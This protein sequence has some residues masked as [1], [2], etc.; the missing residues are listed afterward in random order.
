M[1]NLGLI[2]PYFFLIFKM[3]EA[4]VDFFNVLETNNF[5][6]LEKCWKSVDSLGSPFN[7][8]ITSSPFPKQ[9]FPPW[10]I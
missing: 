9:I 7:Y 3:L 6:F 2:P 1:Q 5:K 4:G 10:S 8:K